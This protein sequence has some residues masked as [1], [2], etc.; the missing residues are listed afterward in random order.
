M[1]AYV[2]SKHQ[3]FQQIVEGLSGGVLMF[4]EAL[5]LDYMNPAGEMLFE[6]SANRMHGLA[7]E[8]VFP[9]NDALVTAM[10]DAF[11]T[12]LA[13]LAQSR[14]PLGIEVLPAEGIVPIRT[15]SH[16]QDVENRT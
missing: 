1:G 14:Y 8:E 2:K 16:G 11:E 10:H 13:A 3:I 4:N 5:K 12:G 15:R 9:N 6:I 7:L